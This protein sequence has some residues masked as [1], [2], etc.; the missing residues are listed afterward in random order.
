MRN[1]FETMQDVFDLVEGRSGFPSA[2]RGMEWGEEEQVTPRNFDEYYKRVIDGIGIFTINTM[3]R[4]TVIT[5]KDLA[6]SEAQGKPVIK[7]SK[8]EKGFE[9]IERGRYVY[10]YPYMVKFL[11]K[12]K[13]L[14]SEAEPEREKKSMGSG[15]FAATKGMNQKS[16]VERLQAMNRG[17]ENKRAKE[18][19]LARRL[20]DPSTPEGAAMA[21][22]KSAEKDREESIKKFMPTWT[23]I[24]GFDV[25]MVPNPKSLLMAVPNTEKNPQSA[26]AFDVMSRHPPRVF[27]ARVKGSEVHMYL[28]TAFF[29]KSE[30]AM[31]AAS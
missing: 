14:P 10:V 31:I 21:K 24:E 17:I 16:E 25:L 2:G 1:L 29:E 8:D 19:E 18:L 26:K 5:G 6:S 3:T 7:V 4:V 30:K 27:I 9:S 22:V 28:A 12:V 11:L 15:E 23:K 13:A 20:A